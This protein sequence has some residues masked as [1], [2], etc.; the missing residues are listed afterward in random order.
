MLQ[1]RLGREALDNCSHIQRYDGTRV[2]GILY[3]SLPYLSP[4]VDTVTQ[5]MNATR[6]NI[7]FSDVYVVINKIGSRQC[8]QDS[9]ASLILI[10]MLQ[11]FPF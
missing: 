11:N 8:F 6:E 4:E 3:Y 2:S 1:N 10:I 9:P 5:V 7:I